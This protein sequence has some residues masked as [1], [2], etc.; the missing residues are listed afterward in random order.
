MDKLDQAQMYTDFSGLNGLREAAQQ[1]DEKALRKAAEHFESIFMKMMLKSMRQAEEVLADKD[2]PFNSQET[3]F[4]RDMH[5]DQMA[6]D[7]SSSGALG[8]ADLI[9]EQLSPVKG[10]FM[11]AQAL[12]GDASLQNAVENPQVAAVNRRIYDAQLS[13][14]EVKPQTADI[15]QLSSAAKAESDISQPVEFTS[16]QDFVE[17]LLPFAKNAAEKMGL[18]P[19]AMIAQAALETGWGQKMM[20]KFDGQ[21]ALNFFG[22]KADGRWDGDKMAVNTLE[23]RNGIA[24]MEKAQFR[25]Y[26]QIKDSLEDYVSFIQSSPRYEEAVNSAQEPEKYFNA[27]QK[28]G[29]ATDPNYADKIMSVLKDSVFE[30]FDN[31]LKF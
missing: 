5:D 3:K 6:V 4:Y 22:I 17:K 28:A 19:L 11:P 21:N 30:S 16:K 26:S 18:P 10:Q 15:T 25:A 31:V 8:L 9:V 14:A 2:S 7:L 24:Q 1:N 12:R 13:A 29:Y 20:K 23:Y 27:L